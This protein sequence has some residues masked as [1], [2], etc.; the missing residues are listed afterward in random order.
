MAQRLLVDSSWND[1][2]IE[3]QKKPYFQELLANVKHEYQNYEC[4]PKWDNIFRVFT[5]TPLSKVKVVILGQDP[6]HQ[7][8]QAH[9]LAFSVLP[10]VTLPSSLRNIFQELKADLQIDNQQNGYLVDWAKEGVFLLNTALTV[11]RS[12]PNSHSH[13][14]WNIFTDSVL[15]YLNATKDHLVFVLWGN[16]ARQK[17]SLIDSS[18]HLIVES[19]HPSFYS[20][21]RGFFG[22]KPFSRTNDWLVAHQENPINWN[23]TKSEE[24]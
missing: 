20:A 2:F 6:Y 23:L 11:R 7:P 5:L 18:K 16:N 1:F 24:Q 4:F 3:E 10:G 14:H 12:Q 13:Y 22:S 19:P 8:N 17:K 15:S 21:D 9:G